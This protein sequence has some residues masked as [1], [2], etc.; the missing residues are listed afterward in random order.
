MFWELLRRMEEFREELR[1]LIADLPDEK[2][3]RILV[4]VEE[5]ENL[6][7]QAEMEAST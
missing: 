3:A 4:I 5:L 1:G 6:S 2:R 7:A